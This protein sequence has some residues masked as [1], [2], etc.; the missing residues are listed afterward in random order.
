[1]SSGPLTGKP[2]LGSG[3]FVIPSP[4][5]QPLAYL[6]TAFMFVLVIYSTT[7]QKKAKV[8]DLNP[9]KSRVKFPGV[10]P[11]EQRR[12]FVQNSKDLFMAGRA[13][14]PD[15]PYRLYSY[16]GDAVIIPPNMINE[17][18]NEEALT[19]S[20]FDF[21]GHIRG[22]DGFSD[23]NKVP[24]L[25]NK[26][27]TKALNKLTKPLSNESGLAI[28]TNFGD[29][30]TE[31]HAI[32]PSSDILRVV[33]RVSTRIFMGEELCRNEEWLHAS[34]MY[35]QTVFHAVEILRCYPPAV[36]PWVAS[37]LPEVKAVRA[38]IAKCREILKPIIAER[39][40]TKAAAIAR[41]E[42]PPPYDDTLEW[43]EKENGPDFDHAKAQIGLSM[44]AI[45]TTSDLMQE[46]MIRITQH[47]E[48][49]QVL[50]NE[51]VEVLSK[52]GLTKTALYNLKIMDSVMKE[53]QRL[54]TATLI[55]MMR[56]ASKDVTLSNGLVIPR[57]ERVWVDTTH[58]FSG[59][60]WKNPGEFDPY[61]FANLRGTD[62]EHIAPLV[63]TSAEH[64]AFGHGMHSCPGRFF[65]DK[66][67][68]ILLCHLL[69]K[70]DW[71]LQEGQSSDY[72]GW[73]LPLVR[74][75]E[76]RIL[77]KRRESEE[78]DLE[79]LA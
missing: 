43:C 21:H 24:G 41:G 13:K 66:E 2:D 8:P 40:A 73:G 50:R 65:A 79:S 77:V 58:M 35:A 12:D 32:H 14:F 6:M 76:L 9:P 69:L 70:Y 5:E 61:R 52:D 64:I 37:F 57:G 44:A 18:R 53:S 39:R 63:S 15:Q 48:L 46:M 7:G 78:I 75:Q 62:K 51:I 36:R 68:K 3:S 22:F 67:L 33:A 74:D 11:A 59:K 27:L 29:S 19:T 42:K 45:H 54:K 31:W 49:F 72:F 16:L 23:D 20:A 10:I 60:T 4:A 17:I 47:P 26:Y 56:R 28:S 55:G 25:I 34:A 30:K 1:M 71:R 38:S